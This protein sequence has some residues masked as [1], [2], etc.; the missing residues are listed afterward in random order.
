MEIVL[1]TNNSHKVEELTR[2]LSKIFPDVKIKSLGEAGFHEEIEE[3]ATTL[4]GNAL[5]KAQTVSKKLGVIAVSDD[6]GLLV[7]ALNGEPGVYSARYAGEGCTPEDNMKKLLSV[8]KDIPEGKRTAH[9]ETSICCYF[10]DGKTVYGT[11]RCEGKILFSKEGSGGFGYD[12]IFFSDKLGKS[13]GV[14][15]A[16]EKDSVSHR[17]GALKDLAEKL[18]NGKYCN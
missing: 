18:T 9:F 12:P 2:V 1:A 15:T 7:N 14:A 4:A 8:M 6:T 13:F 17:S 11:G 16:E 10:P 5:I 3:T